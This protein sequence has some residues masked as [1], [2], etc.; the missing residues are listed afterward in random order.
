LLP[1][2]AR[3]RAVL[4]GNPVRPELLQGEAERA[5]S[6]LGLEGFDRSLP[7][8]Y[9]TGGAMGARQINSLVT[10]SLPWLL[11]RANVVHQCGE[12]DYDKQSAQVATLPDAL[13][14]RYRLLPFVGTELPDVYALADLVVARSGAGTVAE[15][16]A[17]GKPALLIPMASS[18]G[19][20]QAR[21]ARYLADNGAARMLVGVFGDEEFRA[22]LEPML[23]DPAVRKEMG[24]QAG[25]LGRPDAADALVQVILR[26]VDEG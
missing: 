20:E 4:V 5:I 22:A 3:A 17:L 15:L 2:R 18:A 26:I 9:V 21:N 19:G 24:A 7:T 25:S 12:T 8:V 13:A 6:A 14:A 10:G 16:T 1:G 23:A 11:G